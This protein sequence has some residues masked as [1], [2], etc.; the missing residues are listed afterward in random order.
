MTR[1]TDKR[2]PD[3][4]F[5]SL[6]CA[7]ARTGYSVYAFRDKISEGVLPAYRLNDRPGSSIRV[8]VADVDALLK[9][10]V[11]EPSTHRGRFTSRKAAK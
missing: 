4:V 3:P 2:R 1:A 5:E 9:P 6:Q 10:Y 8:K 7:A 11:P